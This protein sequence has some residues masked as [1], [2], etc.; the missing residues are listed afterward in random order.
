MASV[1]FAPTIVSAGSKINVIPSSATLTVDCR[2]PPGHARETA[3]LR[4]REV[5]GHDDGYEVTWLEEVVGNGSP[6]ASPLM[7][8]ITHWLAAEDSEA[9]IVPTML[10][11]YTDSRAF[12]D[13]FPECVAYGFFP[14]REMTLGEMWPLVHGK[15]ERIKAA[16]VGFAARAYKAIVLDLLS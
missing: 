15:D 5:I 8:A 3:A 11:A 12:R 16:D 1:T 6:V 13:A 10:P 14:Q 2:V 9:R 7:D 4:L